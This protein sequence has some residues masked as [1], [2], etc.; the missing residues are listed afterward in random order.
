M[1]AAWNGVAFD[2]QRS[3]TR[4]ITDIPIAF[5]EIRERY[6]EHDPHAIIKCKRIEGS[7]TDLW[8]PYFVEGIARFKKG[9]YASSHASG[10]MAGYLLSGSPQGA[11]RGINR[12]SDSRKLR[13]DRLGACS[14]RDEPW[15]RSSVHQR[16]E[17]KVPITLHHAFLGF[18]PAPS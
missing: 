8:R 2:A 14:L 15:A 13:G 6:H 3:A 5:T 4:R 17:L 9:K 18:R 11:T 10:F 16:P 7:G 12:Y 1:G